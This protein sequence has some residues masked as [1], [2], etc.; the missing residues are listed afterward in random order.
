MLADVGTEVI[1][2][3]N[4]PTGSHAGERTRAGRKDLGLLPEKIAVLSGNSPA[5][6]P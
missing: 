2:I 3:E 1:K 5:A 6:R 4:W